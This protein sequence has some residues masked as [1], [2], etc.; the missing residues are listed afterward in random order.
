MKRYIKIILLSLLIFAGISI[1]SNVNAATADIKASKTQ[2]TVG[3]SVTITVTI[4]AA[5][6]NLKV[7]G[8][9]VTAQS[10]ADT[11]ND[12]NNTTKTQTLN[13]DTRNSRLKNNSVIR[14]CS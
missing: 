12:G 10:Y 2:A 11:T 3:D 13:L 9:G 5:A 14:R 4:N 7:S 8:T 6:W 1:F